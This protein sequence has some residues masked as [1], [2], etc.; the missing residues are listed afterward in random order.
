MDLMPE[1]SS[2]PPAARRRY[3]WRSLTLGVLFLPLYLGSQ[4]IDA[5]G[6]PH[7]LVLAMGYGGVLALLWLLYEFQHLIR[8]LDE[9]QQ[10]IHITALAIGF[11]MIGTLATVIGMTLE[12]TNAD[13]LSGGLTAVV[14]TL[15]MPMGI[16]GYYIA[17]HFVKRRYE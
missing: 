9:L 16:A 1:A 7:A 11:G 5:E 14:A 15:T 3:V 4:I 17:L 13:N 2:A 10:K 6:A 12:L 8:Q